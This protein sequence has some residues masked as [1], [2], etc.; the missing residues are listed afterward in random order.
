[1]HRPT[2]TDPRGVSL[3]FRAW[4]DTLGYGRTTTYGTSLPACTA[5]EGKREEAQGT[6]A[7]ASILL[8]T[9]WRRMHKAQHRNNNNKSSPPPHAV[10]FVKLEQYLRVH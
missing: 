6:L 2:A 1:M 5:R 9:G 7:P 4:Y 3:P 8:W 10:V